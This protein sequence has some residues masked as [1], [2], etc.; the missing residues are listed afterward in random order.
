MNFKERAKATTTVKV[1][2]SH[3]PTVHINESALNKMFIFTDEVEDEVGWLGTAYRDD[4]L[5][6]INDVFLFDQQ[7]H[8]AT[9]EITASGLADFAGELLTKPDGVEIW[10]NMKIWGHSHVN[11]GISPSGQDNKQMEEFSEIGHDFFIRLI[12]NKKGELGVDVYDY[13]NGMEFHNAPWL[14]VH[15]VAQDEGKLLLEQQ[16]EAMYQQIDVLEAE[17]TAQEKAQMDSIREPIKEEIKVKV[18]QFATNVV[19]YVPS[20][21]GSRET[22]GNF[23]SRNYQDYQEYADEYENEVVPHY[24]KNS[25]NK[26]NMLTD[27]I[28]GVKNTVYSFFSYQQLVQMANYCFSYQQFIEEMELDGYYEELSMNDL[29]KVWKAVLQLTQTT[30]SWGDY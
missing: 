18:R 6:V 14:I 12:C 22:R 1:R 10:N 21:H 23:Q 5:F 4:N 28:D 8:G 9:T 20:S 26:T 17:L 25:Y 16:L 30:Q 13:T 15:D 11:M 3:I 7:V 2:D 19:S 29:D 27:Q 24:N